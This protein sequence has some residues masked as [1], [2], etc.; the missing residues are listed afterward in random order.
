MMSE[1]NFT[2]NYHDLEERDLKDLGHTL[3]A[4]EGIGLLETIGPGLVEMHEEK[5]FYCTATSG[6][7]SRSVQGA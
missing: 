5:S 3:S 1:P 6:L 4:M 7:N 2:T